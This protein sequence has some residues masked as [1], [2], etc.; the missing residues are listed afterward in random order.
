MNSVVTDPLG[1]FKAIPVIETEE[2]NEETDNENTVENNLSIQH[3]KRKGKSGMDPGR[4]GRSASY[5]TEMASRNARNKRQRETNERNVAYEPN[6]K[7]TSEEIEQILEKLRPCPIGD[8]SLRVF[9]QHTAM[10][11]CWHDAFFMMMFENDV[12]KPFFLQLVREYLTILLE[13]KYL[14][15]KYNALKVNRIA[16]ALRKKYKSKQ[17]IGVWEFLTLSLQRYALLGFL[18]VKEAQAEKPLVK[19]RL[20]NRRPSIGEAYFNEIHTNLKSGMLRCLE[21]GA[22]MYGLSNFIEQ[23]ASFI[24]EQVGT[25]LDMEGSNEALK[26][27]QTVGYYFTIQSYET[28]SY[29]I[30]DNAHTVSLFLCGDTWFFYDNDTGVTPLSKEQSA[31]VSEKGIVSMQISKNS[32]R[33]KYAF[34]LGDG[35]QIYVE[36]PHLRSQNI[37]SEE[38]NKNNVI[39]KLTLQK[40]SARLV[41]KSESAPGAGNGSATGAGA[42]SAVGGR[43]RTHRK[44]RAQMR[45]TRQSR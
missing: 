12:T 3:L 5:H 22:S 4:F 16:F 35:N 43:R 13:K 17:P 21:S 32:K 39:F 25:Q 28:E 9:R 33:M 26:P 29:V 37:N 40:L 19:S 8:L 34:S 27:S 42:G 10:G 2:N 41:K 38:N 20:A 15:L 45:K 18:F 24:Q 6:V 44:K 11:T 1:I 31:Q 14:G 7:F 23:M 30:V 36:M